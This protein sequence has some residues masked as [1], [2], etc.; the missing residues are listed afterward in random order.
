MRELAQESGAH[1]NQI[2]HR[3]EQTT[4]TMPVVFGACKQVRQEPEVD[5]RWPYASLDWH[6]PDQ[7]YY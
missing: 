4:S 3:E 7:A 5:I 6:T 1:A 2:N